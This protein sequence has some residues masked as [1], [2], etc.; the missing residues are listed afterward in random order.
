MN[1]NWLLTDVDSEDG[2]TYEDYYEKKLIE[3]Y[4]SLNE[5]DQNEIIEIVLLKTRLR[6]NL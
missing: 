6:S 3:V 1:L 5:Y 2:I 4:R